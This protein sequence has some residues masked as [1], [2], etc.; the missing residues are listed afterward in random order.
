[1]NSILIRRGCFVVA[2]ACVL[3]WTHPL[4]AQSL[5]ANGPDSRI[6]VRISTGRVH[7]KPGEDIRIHVEIWNESKQDLFILKDIDSISNALAKINLTL[8]RG[9]HAVGPFFSVAADCFCSERSTYPPLANELPRYW[10]AVSPKHFYGGEVVMKAPSFEKLSVLGRYRIQGKYSSRGFL[11]QDIN[12]PLAHYADQL[13]QLP[14]EA[15]VGDIET[16]S[17]WIEVSGKP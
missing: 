8:Y 4:Q 1:M 11:A 17:I 2:L 15:W 13:K 7:F 16:N 14:Y 12:N 5:P 9:D 3:A 6:S 10:I